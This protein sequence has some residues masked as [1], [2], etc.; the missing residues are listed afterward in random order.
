MK[1]LVTGAFGNVGSNVTA[2]LLDLGHSVRALSAEEARDAPVAATFGN[3]IEVVRGDV[4]RP[5]DL[6]TA[7]DGCDAIVHLAFVIPPLCLEQPKTSRDINV[8]GT[9]NVIEAA[10]RAA[11]KSGGAPRLVFASTL[12]VYGHTSHLP[13]PRRTDDPVEATDL[14]TEHKIECEEMVRSSGLQWAIL[15]FADVPP[16]ALRD[17]HPI[18]FTIPLAQRIEMI[19]PR[20]IGL[21]V[22]R[23]VGHDAVWGRVLNIGGGRSCQL[24]YG[25][26][27]ESLLEAMGIGALPPEWF[28]TDPYCTDWLDTDESQR[29]LQYQRHDFQDVVRET[30]ALLGWRAPLVRL[31]RPLLRRRIGRLA[32]IAADARPQPLP[33]NGKVPSPPMGG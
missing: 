3:R 10:R 21:A 16:I 22:A 12:D 8:G 28:T 2:S 14:Y 7:V 6:D 17:P 25:Q 19:H 4:R 15:R 24:T 1:I 23:A 33:R 20:D 26:Y 18:M 30:A 11:Q 27:L 31:L 9:R 32:K 29:L 5:E 13:P